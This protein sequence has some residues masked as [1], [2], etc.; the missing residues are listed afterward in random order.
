M[1]Q[2]QA[3]ARAVERALDVYPNYGDALVE[4]GAMR[5][6]DGNEKGAIADW[7]LVVKLGPKSRA[8]A[9]AGEYLN[10]TRR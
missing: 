7:N 8:A 5:F 9:L 2:P 4:R 3:G 6:E 1:P 10:E